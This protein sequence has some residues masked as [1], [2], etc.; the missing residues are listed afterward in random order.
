MLK[1][2][3]GGGLRL[4]LDRAFCRLRPPWRVDS[5][6]MVGREAIPG[7]SFEGKAVL[8]SDHYGLLLSLSAA[9]Q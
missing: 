6:E 7:E 3:R 4:R 8:P 9:A 1:R 5:V 2:P